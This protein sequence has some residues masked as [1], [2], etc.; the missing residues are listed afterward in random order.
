MADY[1][2]WPS[3]GQAYIGSSVNNDGQP[4]SAGRGNG[5]GGRVDG[6]G[7]GD[8]G[9]RGGGIPDIGKIPDFIANSSGNGG[10][11]GNRNKT[12][13]G[14]I[15]FNTGFKDKEGTS[16]N[17]DIPKMNENNYNQWAQTVR[18]VLDGKGKLG[19]LTGAFAE[20]A[21]GDP[22]HQQ[23]KSEN[24]MIIVWL[25][26]TMETGIGKPYMFLPSAKD[27][28]EAVK[29]TYSDIQNAS[30]IFGL[31]SQLWHTKQGDRNVTTYYIELLTSWQ[32]LDLCYDDNWKCAE[33]SVLFLKR[34]ENDRVFMFLAGLNK[35]LDERRHDK[36]R[37][38]EALNLKARLW[39]LETP[40]KEKKSDEV[41]RCDYCNREW[42][43]REDCW[44]LKGKPPNWTPNWKKKKGGRAFQASNYD[45]GR[46]S[47]ST[48]GPFT[49]EQLEKLFKLLESETPS[50]S[51]ATKG[52]QKLKVAYGS[53]SAIVGKGSIVLSPM[54]TLKNVLHVPNLSCSLTSDLNSGKMIGSAEESGGL[55][56]FDIGSTSQLPSETISSCFESFS[57]LNNHDDNIMLWHLRLGHP[58]FP[59][60]KHL[61]PKLF[62]N[63][64]IS[65]FKCEACEFAK[66]HRSHFAIQPYKPSKL[67][68]II[69]SDVWGPNRT[70][71][72]S[73]KKWFI[74]F[75]DDHSRVEG[76]DLIKYKS[77]QC[78]LLC[79]QRCRSGGMDIPDTSI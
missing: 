75:I 43:T 55:Y 50:S 39:Q 31:K 53:F 54:L 34:Q 25:V 76:L 35:D 44:K 23:W 66:H 69:H 49:T 51:V 61:F 20:P 19:F 37:H 41:P 30:Q 73:L 48:Q 11:N 13:Y 72:L 16:L 2:K 24:S 27:V 59:Y 7:R 22:L 58:S 36:A 63:K 57:V 40:T 47:T 14:D 1:N 52:N 64:D 21:Q 77:I 4:P 28:W 56:Y 15:D 29:E 45:Q 8:G 67:F 65:L 71:T 12:V 46:Q 33:D 5:G 74:T 32:E 62:R 17:V 42:H 60:L 68:S 6:A 9:G 38:L 26:S 10:N 79:H 18:L 70:S 3:L 78:R